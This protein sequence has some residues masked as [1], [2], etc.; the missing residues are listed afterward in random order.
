MPVL[1]YFPSAFPTAVSLV[2]ARSGGLF[3]DVVVS[4]QIDPDNTSG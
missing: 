1:V 2:V 4:W 3:G